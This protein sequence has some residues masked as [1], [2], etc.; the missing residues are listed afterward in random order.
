MA[1]RK[2]AAGLAKM[3]RLLGDLFTIS[4][5]DIAGAEAKR[6]KRPS[7]KRKRQTKP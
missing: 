1:K 7:P 4:K 5:D 2:S 3:N 6:L